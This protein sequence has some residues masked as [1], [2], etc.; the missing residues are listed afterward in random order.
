M[1]EFNLHQ[2]MGLFLLGAL[3]FESGK[4]AAAVEAVHG[5][6]PNGLCTPGQGQQ[7]AVLRDIQPVQ[8]PNLDLIPVNFTNSLPQAVFGGRLEYPVSNPNPQ[9]VP[10]RLQPWDYGFTNNQRNAWV[11]V[12]QNGPV[13]LPFYVGRGE[14]IIANPPPQFEKVYWT[15]FLQPV[16]GGL[17]PAGGLILIPLV[18]N[19][20]NDSISDKILEVGEV[21]N[22][23]LWLNPVNTLSE[24]SLIQYDILVDTSEL[25]YVDFIAHHQHQFDGNTIYQELSSPI[26]HGGPSTKLA[27]FSFR[28]HDPNSWPGDGHSDIKI[29]NIVYTSLQQRASTI[30]MQDIEFEVQVPGPLPILGVGAFFKY[31]R[32]IR[33]LK[34]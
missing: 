7:C 11:G 6:N 30:D 22:F 31:S 9:Q 21:F 18:A 26:F 15:P 29:S 19:I 33:R 17:Q 10:D 28:A 14:L 24:I 34:R 8:L 2:I 16:Q 27:T 5:P 25:S 1:N 32:K 12:P 23:E 4:A 13:T 20:D 3:T